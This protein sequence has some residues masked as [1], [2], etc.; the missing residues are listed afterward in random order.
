[1]MLL[2]DCVVWAVRGGVMVA[3]V[4]ECGAAGENLYVV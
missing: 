4:V 3:A 1:M 2:V